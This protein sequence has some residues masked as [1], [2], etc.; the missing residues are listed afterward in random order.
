MY[1]DMAGG[2]APINDVSKS[3]VYS[4]CEYYNEKNGKNI[5]PESVLSKKPSAE[6]S[7]KQYDPFDY[8]VISPLVDDIIEFNLGRTELLDKGYDEKTIDKIYRM[9]KTSEYKRRQAPPGIK[10]T[11]K[12]FG[13]GRRMP[14]INHYKRT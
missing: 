8:E 6:L 13:I 3:K 4:L 12:A 9:I 10:I 5:I 14:L 11:S 7:E 1:G 2:L